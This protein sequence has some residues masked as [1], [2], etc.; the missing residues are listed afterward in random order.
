MFY[1]SVSQ[2]NVHLEYIIDKDSEGVVE[3]ENLVSQQYFERLKVL[4]RWTNTMKFTM[5]SN[6]K[7]IWLNF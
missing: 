5:I 2:G 3:Y 7:I 4:K 1:V 6:H